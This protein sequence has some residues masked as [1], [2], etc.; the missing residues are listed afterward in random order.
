MESFVTGNPLTPGSFLLI[1]VKSPVPRVPTLSYLISKDK[2]LISL[3]GE[4]STYPPITSWPYFYKYG[5]FTAYFQS[6]IW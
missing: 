6:I 4:F 1:I 2:F 3:S 5:I